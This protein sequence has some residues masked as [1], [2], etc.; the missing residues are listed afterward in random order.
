MVKPE[1]PRYYQ[2]Q[3]NTGVIG[4][5]INKLRQIGD[6]M[7]WKEL[8]NETAAIIH[9]YFGFAEIRQ[10]HHEL[11]DLHVVTDDTDLATTIN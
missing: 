4:R 3:S 11:C 1:E 2:I 5:H 9:P 10:T 6:V 7:V 8:N